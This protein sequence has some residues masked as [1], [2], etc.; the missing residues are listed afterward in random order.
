M[1]KIG[2][3]FSGICV[4]GLSF[5]A[6][7]S[8]KQLVQQ[9][10]TLQKLFSE[11]VKYQHDLIECRGEKFD[12][13]CSVLKVENEFKEV[14]KEIQNNSIFKFKNALFGT[15]QNDDFE[16]KS[17]PRD[18]HTST[19]HQIFAEPCGWNRIDNVT[20]T[21]FMDV[22]IEPTQI[23]ERNSEFDVLSANGIGFSGI[24]NVLST[25]KTVLEYPLQEHAKD[26]VRKT[27]IE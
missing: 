14:Q 3:A 25:H 24:E 23:L 13:M 19:C 11:I 27:T 15:S 7:K 26:K 5:A 17:F 12:L 8:H 21:T 16:L 18:M 10:N 4:G 20:L 6:F 22:C 1:L 2:S 9:G